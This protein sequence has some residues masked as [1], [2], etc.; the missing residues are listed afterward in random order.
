MNTVKITEKKPDSLWNY[1]RD[2]RSD[3]LSSSS[4]SSSSKYKTS[5][6]GNTHHFG[7]GEAGYDTEKVGKN[8]AKIVVPLKHLSNFCRTLN[9]SLINYEIEL[10]LTLS[11]N[12]ALVDI[13][14]RAAGNN[15]DPPAIV[16]PTSLEF[17]ITDTKLHVQLVTLSKGNDT[18]LLEQLI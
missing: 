10:I 7:D 3:P 13:T 14:A 15:N 5:I 12:C 4:E 6:T 11:K 2:E 9:I 8:K 1:Y 16:A 18:K 17:Q